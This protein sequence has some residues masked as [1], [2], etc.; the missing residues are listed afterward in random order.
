LSRKDTPVTPGLQGLSL[1]LVRDLVGGHLLVLQPLAHGLQGF[2]GL[3]QVDDLGAAAGGGRQVQ[4]GGIGGQVAPNVIVRL[5]Q[6]QEHL[7]GLVVVLEL[8]RLEGVDEVD[9]ELTFRLRRGSLVGGAEEQVAGAFNTPVLPFQR[10][11]PDQVAGDVGGFVGSLHQGLDRAEVG[12]VQGVVGQRF[13]ALVDLGVVV[14]VLLQVEVILFGVG[15]AGDELAVDGLED[16]AQHGFHQRQQVGCWFAA[17]LR[18]AGVVQAQG[19]AQLQRCWPQRD[20]DVAACGQTMHRQALNDAQRNGLVS[21]ARERLLHF[22]RKH[23]RHLEDGPDVFVGAE[24]GVGRHCVPEG[25]EADQAGAI[26]RHVLLQDGLDLV[27]QGDQSASLLGEHQA[28]ED[29]DVVGVHGKQ[30]HV[31]VHALV[32][33]AIELGERGEHVADALLLVGC[34][35]EQPLGDNEADILACQQHLREAVL[36]PAQAVGHVLEAAAVEDGL[37]HAGHEAEAQVLG[38]LA[39]FTQEGQVEDEIVVLA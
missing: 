7:V 19:V 36:H 25:V 28:L 33:R 30:P 18:N 12:A 34:F 22:G 3:V 20:V 16:L 26:G 27:A 1:A 10:V 6:P 17:K 37:L 29:T 9:V 39:D 38:D 2:L 21:R 8:R 14:D 35:L 31:V 11:L 23:L 32:H 15:R 4:R 13:G 24:H 5:L